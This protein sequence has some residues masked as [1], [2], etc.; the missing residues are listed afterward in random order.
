MGVT[1]RVDADGKLINHLQFHR[2]DNPYIAGAT[3]G[4]I[5]SR[6]VFGHD[7][8]ELVGAR[9][10]VKASRIHHRGHAWNR[11]DAAPLCRMDVPTGQRRENDSDAG[12]YQ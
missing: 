7:R 2:V 12:A 10:T 11:L 8:A 5:Y 1:P 3:I 4:N 9:F 6:K